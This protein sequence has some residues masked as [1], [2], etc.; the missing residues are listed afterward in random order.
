[1]STTT[2]AEQPQYAKLLGNDPV[3]LRCPHLSW[4]GQAEKA[5]VEW[6]D[7][8]QFFV[9]T[10]YD[11]VTEVMR[12]AENVSGL[13]AMGLKGA[14][15]YDR[16]IQMASERAAGY[17]PLSDEEATEARQVLLWADAP[18][19]TTHRAMVNAVVKPAL[20]K[21][22]VGPI[23]DIAD[24]TLRPLVGKEEIDYRADVALPFAMDV[25]MLLMGFPPEDV[26]DCSRWSHDFVKIFGA[27]DPESVVDELATSRAEFAG[28]LDRLLAARLDDP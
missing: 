27:S 1:M 22:W 10:R 26:E 11:L 21:E 20:I 6:F 17:A 15:A 23:R 19:H 25:I 28:Y 8:G 7:E 3:A 14:V 13:N 4:R 18:R 16:M 24:R 12:D 2:R 5:P 9:V